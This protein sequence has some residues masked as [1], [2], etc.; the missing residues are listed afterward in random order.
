MENFLRRSAAR[1]FHRNPLTRIPLAIPLL[2]K[3]AEGFMEQKS[4]GVNP[5]REENSP[6]IKRARRRD[7]ENSEW[8]RRWLGLIRAA[9][10]P[11]I[12]R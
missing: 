11:V 1:E 2:K 12:V 6:Q 10:K 8:F 7:W 5:D 4:E 9:S 3:S